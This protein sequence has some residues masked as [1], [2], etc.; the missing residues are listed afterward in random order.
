MRDLVNRLRSLKPV[1]FLGTDWILLTLAERDWLLY[2]VAAAEHCQ[3]MKR[4][5]HPWSER[6]KAEEALDRI[7]A[8]PPTVGETP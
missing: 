7:L 5:H 2:V 6:A 8:A 1:R 3:E 4:P